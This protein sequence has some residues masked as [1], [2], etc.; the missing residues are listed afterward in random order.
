MTHGDNGILYAKDQQYKP[1]RLWSY[2]TSDGPSDVSHKIPTHA[3]FM[4]AYSTIPDV[5]FDLLLF[6]TSQLITLFFP[7]DFIPGAIQLMDHGSLKHYAM[8][9]RNGGEMK[10]CFR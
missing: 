4:I 3:D 1:E 5:M 9:C 2:S 6:L 7:L 10:T 8:F